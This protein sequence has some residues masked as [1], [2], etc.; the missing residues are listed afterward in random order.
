MRIG[1]LAKESGVTVETIRFY[2]NEGLLKSVEGLQSIDG[3][4][5]DI[6]KILE[7]K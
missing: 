5:S 1:E 7:G 3:V 6:L 4:F 2:E